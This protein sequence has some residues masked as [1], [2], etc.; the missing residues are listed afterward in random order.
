MRFRKETTPL[1]EER[2]TA[3]REEWVVLRGIPSAEG[4]LADFECVKASAGLERQGGDAVLPLPGRR[5]LEASPWAGG[6]GLFELC[7]RAVEHQVPEVARFTGGEPPASVQVRVR[8]APGPGGLTLFWEE[9]AEPLDAPSQELA[10]LRALLEGSPE[11]VFAKNLEGQYILLNPTAARALGR[12]TEQPL[13]RSRDASAVP[14]RQEEDPEG[15]CRERFIGMLGH[16]LGNPL[17]AIRLTSAALLAREALP[18][19]VRRGLERIEGSAGRMA[20]MVRQLLDFT[21]ARMGGGIPLRPGEVALDEVCRQVIGELELASPGREIRLETRGHCR[22]FWD[23]E[24]IS[25]VV[26][27]LVAN[28]LQHSPA[29]TPI[30]V[31]LEGLDSLQ[32]IEVHNT[33][34]PIPEELRPR[35]FEPFLR[36][37]RGPAASSGLGLGLGLYIVAQLVQAHGGCVEASSTLEDGTR[38]IVLLPRAVPAAGGTVEEGTVPQQAYR[39]VAS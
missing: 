3:S 7:A 2:G 13:G 18:Q 33:G 21:R 10:V 1:S 31:S 14:R 37:E 19:E 29:G 22:G 15:R 25:Q 12:S 4:A 39:V 34:Q 30:R 35:L 27:N 24:R 11:A 28:A 9:R 36:A 5:L 38:F 32:R 17:S 8:A 16:D 6:C 23:L 20:R 26:S